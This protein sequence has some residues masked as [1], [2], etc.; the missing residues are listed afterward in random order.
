M[1]HVTRFIGQTGRTLKHRLKEPKRALTSGD[2]LY[3]TSA[4]ADHA[5]SNSHGIVWAHA[6]VVDFQQNLRQRCLLESWYIEKEG[7]LVM[8]RGK[9]VLAE[10]YK[11]V[12]LPWLDPPIV[13]L[14]LRHN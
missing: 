12:M 8:N 7:N 3:N 2:C 13:C 11:S 1:V 4:V 6:M 14:A 5:V 9:L 10:V